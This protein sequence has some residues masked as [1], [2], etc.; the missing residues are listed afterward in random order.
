MVG[1]REIADI[2]DVSEID[3]DWI[4]NNYREIWNGSPEH[5][6]LIDRIQ[7][8]IFSITNRLYLLRSRIEYDINKGN[9]NRRISRAVDNASKKVGNLFLAFLNFEEVKYYN[10][11]RK[12][13]N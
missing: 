11:K 7:G 13:I 10:L 8:Q 12:L 9:T 6:E 1:K 3:L 5:L 4:L 2:L